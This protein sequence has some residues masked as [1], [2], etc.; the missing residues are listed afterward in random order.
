[1]TDKLLTSQEAARYL[2]VS[3]ST[4]LRWTYAGELVSIKMGEK[5]RSPRRFQEADLDTFIQRR[6][7]KLAEDK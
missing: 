6:K 3:L 1:M 4:L 7:T 5:R 2:G